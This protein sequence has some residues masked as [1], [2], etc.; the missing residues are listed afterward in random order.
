MEKPKD[1]YEPPEIQRVRLARDELA[2]VACKTS[3]SVGGPAT[4]CLRGLAG[5][6]RTNGS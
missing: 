4:G 3:V 5:P 1:T 6:C 2:A